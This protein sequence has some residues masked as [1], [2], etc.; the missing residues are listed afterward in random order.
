MR[1][2]FPDQPTTRNA[3]AERHR[4]ARRAAGRK[5]GFLI[6]AAVFVLVNGALLAANVS[7]GGHGRVWA[8]WPLLGWGLGLAIHGLVAYGPIEG[9]RRRLVARELE[10]IRDSG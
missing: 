8:A 5:L 1:S 9:L 10:R 7:T 6:H 3:G 4:Q 2:Q